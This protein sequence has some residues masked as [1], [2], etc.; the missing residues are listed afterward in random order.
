MSQGGSGENLDKCV[1]RVSSHNIFLV[2][3]G[4]FH[5]RISTQTT[6]EGKFCHVR[7]A[8]GHGKSLE[9]GKYKSELLA[10]LARVHT[11]I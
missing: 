5:Q 10:D 4:G 8:R 3:A 7:L 11:L 9:S 6:N 2:C 1:R